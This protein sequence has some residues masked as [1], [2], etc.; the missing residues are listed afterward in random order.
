MAAGLGVQVG[1]RLQDNKQ[2][3]KI[4][5]NTYTEDAFLV[6]EIDITD[7]VIALALEKLYHDYDIDE[8]DK[9][10][11]TKQKSIPQKHIKIEI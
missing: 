3:G 11:I 7:K 5:L 9:L 4:T 6:S 10:L 8:G 1:R 2:T